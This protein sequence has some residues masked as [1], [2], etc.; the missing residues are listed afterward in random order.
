LNLE[1]F[2]K[3]ILDFKGL[4]TVGQGFVDEVFRVFQNQHPQ[5]KIEWIHENADIEFMIRRGL[6]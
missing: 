1:Q 3:I 6:R 4:A 5:I 2:S